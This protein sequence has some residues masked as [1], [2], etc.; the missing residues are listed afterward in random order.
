MQTSTASGKL[1]LIISDFRLLQHYNPYSIK[2]CS[3]LHTSGGLE[4]AGL[5]YRS[6]KGCGILS[7]CV[8]LVSTRSRNWAR[9]L[10]GPGRR[11]SCRSQQ[12]LCSTSH[13]DISLR[14]A[15][16]F[17]PKRTTI[18]FSTHTTKKTNTLSLPY[19]IIRF[20]N[21]QVLCRS[22]CIRAGQYGWRII[23][24]FIFPFNNDN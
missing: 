19:V 21:C 18:F 15:N 9:P 14:L 4:H 12:N 23:N 8:T 11:A 7:V 13:H 10:I 24:I 6:V 16:P 17:R 2:K 20:A 22:M 5:V 3:Q 1:L